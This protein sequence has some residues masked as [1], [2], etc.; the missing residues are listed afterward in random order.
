MQPGVS[1][2]ALR[3]MP[4]VTAGDDLAAMIRVALAQ[5]GISLRESDLLVVAQKIV[6]K[7]E[8]RRLRLGDAE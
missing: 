8:G 6:S 3:G 4:E 2:F 5:A 1:F 7:S